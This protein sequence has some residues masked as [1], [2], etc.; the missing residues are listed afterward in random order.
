MRPE[1]PRLAWVDAH[2]HLDSVGDGDPEAVEAAIGRARSAG[3]GTMVTIGTDLPTSRAAVRIAGAHDGVWAAVGVHPHDASTLDGA[4]L[5]EL[6]SLASGPRVVA[7]GEIGLDFYR[8]LSPRDAQR[9]AFRRQLAAARDLDRAVVIHM[10]D[11][12]EEVFGI[13][14]ESGPPERLVF[15]CFSGGPDDARRALD[16]GGYVSFAGN[17]SYKNA[18]SLREAAASV[19]LDRLLV[20]TDS[21]YL[22]PVPY[23]GKPNEPRFV[24]AVGA[25]LAA[26]VGRPV[27]EIAAATRANAALVFGLPEGQVTPA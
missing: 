4:A 20:E 12:H 26:A 19:P 10:R 23:R 17:V 3:V 25:A 2:C 27:E 18:G 1:A 13:L 9:D 15:H 5:E 7:V 21:P 24:P 6:M 16:L 22:A 8:D 11:S 14:G